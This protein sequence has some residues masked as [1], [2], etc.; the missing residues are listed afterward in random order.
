VTF[1]DVVPAGS[2]SMHNVEEFS[3][4]DLNSLVTAEPACWGAIVTGTDANC[5]P[6]FTGGKK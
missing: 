1:L 2:G 6:G 5:V 4:A 3:L